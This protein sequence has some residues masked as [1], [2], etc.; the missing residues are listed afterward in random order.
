MLSIIPP[1]KPA[2]ACAEHTLTMVMAMARGVG[3][4]A[5]GSIIEIGAIYAAYM[6]TI[7]NVKRM[8]A[9]AYNMSGSCLAYSRDAVRVGG[10][11]RIN[12]VC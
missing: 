5:G 7:L 4:S 6:L 2:M 9:Y 12:V 3:R 11:L 1:S 8:L 10:I